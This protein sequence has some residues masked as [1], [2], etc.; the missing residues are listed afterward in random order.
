MMLGFV[1][2]G[3]PVAVFLVLVLLPAGRAAA[4]GLV[5]GALLIG[6]VWLARMLDLGPLFTGDAH[7]DGYMVAALSI[8]TGA[9]AVAAIAQGIRAAMG[10]ARPRWAYPLIVVVLF[11]ISAVPA[12]YVLGV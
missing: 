8:L 5:V 6:L 2:I 7:A 10:P 9:A 1:F 11:L 4:V 3:L 12:L